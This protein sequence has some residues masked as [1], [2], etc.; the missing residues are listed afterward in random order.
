MEIYKK[1]AKEIKNK[2]ND[3]NRKKDMY[4]NLKKLLEEI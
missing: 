1:A 4:E 2:L 3:I